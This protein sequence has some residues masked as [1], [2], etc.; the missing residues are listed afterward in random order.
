LGK[1]GQ[2]YS[3]KQH[4]TPSIAKLCRQLDED[5]ARLIG[6]I[7]FSTSSSLN[8]QQSSSSSPDFN[9]ATILSV[10][11]NNFNDYLQESLLSFG[12]NMCGSLMGL[13]EKLN[14]GETVGIPSSSGR[15][16]SLTETLDLNLNVKQILLICRLAHA[17][18]FNCPS[19]KLCFINLNQ[20][21]VQQQRQQLMRLN[22]QETAQNNSVVSSYRKTTQ[23]TDQKVEFYFKRMFCVLNVFIVITFLL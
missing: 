19:L 9:I 7:E 18:P 3:T 6:D 4:T 13:I 5:L 22:S 14:S 1:P 8:D 16:F 20:Q 21:L 23:Q 12:N 15:K 10:D 2:N 11:L 17:I